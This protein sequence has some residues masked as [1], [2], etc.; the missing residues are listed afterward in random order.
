MS[1]TIRVHL[2][3]F[4]QL[5]ETVNCAEE[6][7]LLPSTITVGELKTQLAQRN[8]QWQT[9]FSQTVLCAVNQSI[10]TNEQRLQH[11]DEIAFFPPVTGG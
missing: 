9:A 1:Q 2:L 6:A 4:A 7:L 11:S 3:Y 10:A 5:R 8:S